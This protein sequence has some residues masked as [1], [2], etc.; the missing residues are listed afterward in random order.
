MHIYI[1]IY[2]YVCMY[3]YIYM[4]T[5]TY[6]YIC[7]HLCMYANL[8]HVYIIHIK[9]QIL[10]SIGAQEKRARACYVVLVDKSWSQSWPNEQALKPHIA[11][12][13]V[14]YI[15]LY[16]RSFNRINFRMYFQ[17]VQCTRTVFNSDCVRAVYSFNETFV[18]LTSSL[19]KIQSS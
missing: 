10:W 6:I 13:P 4:C 2:M 8:I 15:R 1:Y 17:P 5:Y 19:W 12:M 18:C 16:V 7:R 9:M 11:G 14:S 3:T